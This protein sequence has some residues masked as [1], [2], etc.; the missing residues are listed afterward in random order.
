MNTGEWEGEGE[1][2][3]RKEGGGEGEALCCCRMDGCGMTWTYT[4]QYN[5]ICFHFT[6]YIIL[7]SQWPVIKLSPHIYRSSLPPSLSL[8]IFVP[9]HTITYI[10][11]VHNNCSYM[12]ATFTIVWTCNNIYFNSNYIF[13]HKFIYI[14][15]NSYTTLYLFDFPYNNHFNIYY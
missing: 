11:A 4:T 1:V 9:L 12:Y 5:T 14:F 7:I 15:Y 8:C 2:W 6:S 10:I 3:W 13:H